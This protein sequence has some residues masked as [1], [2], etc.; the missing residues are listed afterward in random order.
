MHFS[1][2]LYQHGHQS[3]DPWSNRLFLLYHN[4]RP[5]FILSLPSR[6][7]QNMEARTTCV[8]SKNVPD[9]TRVSIQKQCFRCCGFM[10]NV[11]LTLHRAEVSQ[12]LKQFPRYLTP[13]HKNRASQDGWEQKK[14]CFKTGLNYQK[15]TFPYSRSWAT[16][17]RHL[18]SF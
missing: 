3:S 6:R 15:I 12:V 1:S 9:F 7:E 11:P 18:S 4:K 16:Y 17:G 13:C 8:P 2:D 14:F 10:V 5:C